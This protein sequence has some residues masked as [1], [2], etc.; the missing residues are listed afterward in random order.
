[1]STALCSS[2]NELKNTENHFLKAQHQAN[3]YRQTQSPA[4]ARSPSS[5]TLIMAN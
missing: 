5:Q 3:V 1:M 2:P 4:S